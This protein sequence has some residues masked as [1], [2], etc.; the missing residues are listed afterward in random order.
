MSNS[1]LH[2]PHF[3]QDRNS[4]ENAVKS[5]HQ[6][7]KRQRSLDRDRMHCREFVQLLLQKLNDDKHSF[8]ANVKH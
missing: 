7:V 3:V 4:T 2:S 1:L 5:L 6:Q 8:Q